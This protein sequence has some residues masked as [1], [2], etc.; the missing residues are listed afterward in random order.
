MVTLIKS[1]FDDGFIVDLLN[2]ADGDVLRAAL[3]LLFHFDVQ[4]GINL[5]LQTIDPHF[6]PFDASTRT[7]KFV[8]GWYWD[9][10]LHGR[11]MV[12]IAPVIVRFKYPNYEHTDLEWTNTALLE[13]EVTVN[14]YVFQLLG[15][16][17]VGEW[18]NWEEYDTD[19]DEDVDMEV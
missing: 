7:Y 11:N 18:D 10:R 16:R 5:W 3:F 2:E 14:G 1:H 13:V 17:P 8:F 12:D 19:T 4:R 9:A 15:E 6:L